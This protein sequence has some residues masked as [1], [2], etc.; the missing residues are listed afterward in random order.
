MNSATHERRFV[1][2]VPYAKRKG[3]GFAQACPL[4][5]SLQT[6]ILPDRKMGHTT[7]YRF[8]IPSA[9][10]TENDWRDAQ[11]RDRLARLGISIVRT[12]MKQA[13]NAC[14][15]YPSGHRLVKITCRLDEDYSSHYPSVAPNQENPQ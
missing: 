7:R 13:G 11:N 5:E 15:S 3:Q 2:H 12:D 10:K 8:R 6:G 14:P 4:C 1:K 9:L